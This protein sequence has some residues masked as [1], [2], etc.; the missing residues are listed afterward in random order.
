MKRAMTGLLPET[1]I[2][3][4]KVGLEIPYSKWFRGEL[5]SLVDDYL[6][7]D[8]VSASGLFDPAGIDGLVASHMEGRAD[9]GRAIW[10][11]L[12]YMMSMDL[13][14]PGARWDSA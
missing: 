6:G 12:N 5:R 8:R 13:F 9:H 1:I 14:I 3:K 11:L 7:H 10:G 2:R 4:K